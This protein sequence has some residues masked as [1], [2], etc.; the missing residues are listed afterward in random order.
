MLYFCILKRH[1]KN[2]GD[3]ANAVQAYSS[4]YEA[5]HSFHA[6]LTNYAYGY[7]A[8]YDYVSCE[9]END[10]GQQMR[11]EVDDRR[12]TTPEVEE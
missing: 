7:N 8:D 3:W 1:N 11:V 5:I 6:F 9:I 4:Q 12:N 10:A 2:T